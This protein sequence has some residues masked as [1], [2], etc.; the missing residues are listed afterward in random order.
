MACDDE[1]RL[2][3]HIMPEFFLDN[4]TNSINILFPGD[5]MHKEQLKIDDKS[6]QSAVELKSTNSNVIILLFEKIKKI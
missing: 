2:I 1:H 5:S 4:E 6:K 3:E